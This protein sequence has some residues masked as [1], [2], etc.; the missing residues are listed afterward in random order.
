MAAA[1]EI[2]KPVDRRARPLLVGLQ[3]QTQPV[4]AGERGIGGNGGEYIKGELE[5]VGLLG[6]DADPDIVG[7]GEAQE[8]EKDR[9]QLLQ[10]PLLLREHEAWVKRR[11]LDRDAGARERPASRRSGAD[12]GDSGGVGVAVVVGGGAGQ[13]LFA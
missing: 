1:G 2:G 12:G 11:E 8:F 13:R 10:N 9:H 6:I 3:R 7:L 5:L 4:P